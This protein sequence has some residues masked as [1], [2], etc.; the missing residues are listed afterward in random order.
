MVPMRCLGIKRTLATCV[1]QESVLCRR[2]RTR[3]AW[4]WEAG[5]TRPICM[6]KGWRSVECRLGA[7]VSDQGA[8]CFPHR[9]CGKSERHI[10][11]IGIIQ[12]IRPTDLEDRAAYGFEKQQ[13]FRLSAAGSCGDSQGNLAVPAGNHDLDDHGFGLRC[14][15]HALF[16]WCR[17][18]HGFRCREDSGPWAI[19]PAIT[20]TS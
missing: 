7:G 2:Q 14:P 15:G 16:L 4:S 3:D 1:D 12:E 6:A 20:E 9:P 11:A 17:H 13:S 5:F 18:D 8:E 19:S 10:P